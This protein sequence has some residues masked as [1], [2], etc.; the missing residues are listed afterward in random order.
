MI[1]ISLHTTA[2]KALAS[3]AL[4]G[5]AAGVAGLGTYGAFGSSTSAGA[6]VASGQVAISLGASGSVT[7][8]S[9]VASGL[10]AGDTIARAATLTNSG[11]QALS[12]V[13][14]TTRATTSSA[15]DADPA[16]GLQLA[17]DSCSSAWTEAGTAPAVTY[18]CP[19]GAT[20]THVLGARPLIGTD[21]PLEHLASLTPGKTD[22]LRFTGTLPTDAGNGLQGQSSTI[23]FT[24]SATQRPAGNK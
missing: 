2:G 18:T 9:V 24:F 15:L 20:L 17:V 8:F 1:R 6:A 19:V 12:G 23:A 3:V 21:V 22:Y 14:L 4:V 7:S 10:V 16:N 13:S 11:D 5:T